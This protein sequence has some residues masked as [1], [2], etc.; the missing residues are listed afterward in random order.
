[1]QKVTI[2]LAPRDIMRDAYFCEDTVGLVKK[3]LFRFEKVEVDGV[4][5]TGEAA[6]EEMF[7]L[8]NNPYRQ[9]ERVQRYGRGRSVSVGDVVAVGDDQFVCASC[10]WEK[11]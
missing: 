5:D 7:D 6:A 10:G 3:N 1:M 2:L 8:T 9:E 4:A 11:V